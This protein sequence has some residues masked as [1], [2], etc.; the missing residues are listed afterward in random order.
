MK[1]KDVYVAL[2]NTINE[3]KGCLRSFGKYNQ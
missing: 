3:I 2:E 1:L